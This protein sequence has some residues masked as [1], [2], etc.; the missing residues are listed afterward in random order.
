RRPSISRLP[1]S[2]DASDSSPIDTAYTRRGV[3]A[4]IRSAVADVD[5]IRSARVRVKRH[6]IR[7]RA[8]AAA[9]D[10]QAIP[11][12]RE[13]TD[14]AARRRLETLALTSSPSLSV[15]VIPRSS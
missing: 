3:A 7:V 15:R 12:L 11:A 1:V 13:V 8:V 2:A 10:K 4:T 6:S 9:R 5:G 14:A